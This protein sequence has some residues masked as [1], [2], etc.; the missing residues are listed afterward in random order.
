MLTIASSACEIKILMKF[1]DVGYPLI[2][3]RQSENVVDDIE[4][5]TTRRARQSDVARNRFMIVSVGNW[6]V[7]EA[8]MMPHKAVRM[9][10]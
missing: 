7:L 3:L 9:S 5:C 10:R 6:D 4:S 8:S 2:R 1:S